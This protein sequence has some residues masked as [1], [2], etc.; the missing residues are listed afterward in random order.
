M[1]TF[2]HVEQYSARY[3]ELRC[4]V[5]TASQFHRI[6]TSEGEASKSHTA[7]MYELIA[8]RLLNEDFKKEELKDVYWPQRGKELEDEAFECA[9]FEIKKSVSK[10]GFVTENDN[11]I[12]K[13]GCSPDFLVE[14]VKEAGEIKCPAPWTQIGYIL[15]GPD[16]N[17]FQKKYKQQVQGQLL[18]TGYDKIYFVSYHPQMPLC[19][20]ETG[21]DETYIKIMSKL[22]KQFCEKLAK[23][24]VEARKAGEYIVREPVQSV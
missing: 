8:Q 3:W 14:G 4:G 24:L 2:H 11:T 18:V 20:Y 5:P 17:S 16:A 12:Y 22:L 15:D 6:I 21:R 9:S 1:P 23:N 10:I 13:I 7:Y 19:V